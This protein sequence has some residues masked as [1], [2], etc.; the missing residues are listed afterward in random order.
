M[1][2]LPAIGEYLTATERLITSEGRLV[3]LDFRNRRAR[4]ARW[5]RPGRPALDRVVRL[6]ES[7]GFTSVAGRGIVLPVNDPG[8]SSDKSIG[9]G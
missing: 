4:P 1:P 6:A 5:D 7:G 3:I 2:G 9:S 8:R